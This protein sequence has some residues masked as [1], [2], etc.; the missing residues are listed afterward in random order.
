MYSDEVAGAKIGANY[1]QCSVR[2]EL[3]EQIPRSERPQCSPYL[4]A[5]ARSEL[6]V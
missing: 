6:E 2:K 4:D 1:K 5:T 3:W